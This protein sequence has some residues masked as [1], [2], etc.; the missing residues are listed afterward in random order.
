[1]R[2][3]RKG[4]WKKAAGSVVQGSWPRSLTGCLIPALPLTGHAIIMSSPT[5]L[6][7]K[8]ILKVNF[9]SKMLQIL[10]K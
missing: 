10:R 7:S 4:V 1:M 2:R 3:K 9:I 5:S 6:V 8:I